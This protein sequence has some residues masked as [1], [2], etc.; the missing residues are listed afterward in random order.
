MGFDIP[1]A[2]GE[3]SPSEKLK[4]KELTKKAGFDDGDFE[5]LIKESWE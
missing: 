3:F 2:D 5:K 4:L 1:H